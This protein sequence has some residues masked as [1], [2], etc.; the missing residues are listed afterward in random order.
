M[1]VSFNLGS[2]FCNCSGLD[3]SVMSWAGAPILQKSLQGYELC[4]LLGGVLTSGS[5]YAMSL[6]QMLHGYFHIAALGLSSRGCVSLLCILWDL[7]HPMSLSLCT[8]FKQRSCALAGVQQPA[9]CSKASGNKEWVLFPLLSSTSCQTTLKVGVPR[10]S[11]QNIV[12]VK[13]FICCRFLL[14]CSVS[15]GI[16][17]SPYY[18]LP[19]WA[20]SFPSHHALNLIYFNL[21]SHELNS[22]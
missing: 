18:I 5:P 7:G 6:F 17:W 4:K 21:P 13:Y 8:G 2:Q 3:L 9:L 22:Y 20:S 1:V 11:V 12:I 14:L 15:V 19:A 16:M 10:E